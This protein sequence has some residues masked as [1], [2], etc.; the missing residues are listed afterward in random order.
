[1]P[2]LET[3]LVSCGKL[4]DDLEVQGSS[5]CAEIS[6]RLII[7]SASLK[8][9]KSSIS[10]ER[11]LWREEVKQTI[12]LEQRLSASQLKS[13][14]DCHHLEKL[15]EA[16]LKSQTK[17]QRELSGS[18]YKQQL[19]EAENLCN[20]EMLRIN[21]SLESLAPLQAIVSDW[22]SEGEETRSSL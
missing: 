9:L 20:M 8:T 4:L 6:E 17:I 11:E 5:L 1:M 18:V 7:L 15:T 3:F 21:H 12:E 19:L 22:G 14:G 10:R 13:S 16:F 2:E